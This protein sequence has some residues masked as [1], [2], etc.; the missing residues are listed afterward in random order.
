MLIQ[1]LEKRKAKLWTHTYPNS[2]KSHIDFIMINKSVLTVHIIAKHT[3][4]LKQFTKLNTNSKPYNWSMLYN[5][6]DLQ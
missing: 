3:T 6:K 4:H 5:N 2:S 1:S